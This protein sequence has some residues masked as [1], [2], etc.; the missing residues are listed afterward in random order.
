M[1]ERKCIDVSV[2][3]YILIFQW[4]IDSWTLQASHMTLYVLHESLRNT[5]TMQSFENP[6]DIEV[7]KSVA[8]SILSAF[9]HQ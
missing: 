7:E 1:Y 8:D 3:V 5:Y 2:P 6:Q 9:E 4:D